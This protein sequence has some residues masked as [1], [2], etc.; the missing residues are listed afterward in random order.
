MIM[1]NTQ[2]SPE[3]LN[4]Q[5]IFEWE[6]IDF[7]VHADDFTLPMPMWQFNDLVTYYVQK[8]MAK[9]LDNIEWSASY[10]YDIHT[11]DPTLRTDEDSE[12]SQEA[13]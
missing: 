10:G 12:D 9:D 1:E 2:T 3:P 6:P 7:K 4:T 5:L 8:S 13:D 11:Q